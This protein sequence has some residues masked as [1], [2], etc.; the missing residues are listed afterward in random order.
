MW[1]SAGNVPLQLDDPHNECT[2]DRSRTTVSGTPIEAVRQR[3]FSPYEYN[4][5]T[6]LAIA[7]KDFCV[8]ASDTRLSAGYSILSRNSKTSHQL[9]SKAVLATGGCRTDVI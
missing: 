2:G 7:G 3:R 8:I 1:S 9:T 4:G 5:G 6:C